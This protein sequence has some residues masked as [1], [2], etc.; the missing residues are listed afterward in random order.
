MMTLEHD[1]LIGRWESRNGAHVA[2]LWKMHGSGYYYT[3]NG[4][5][6]YFGNDI[7]EAQAIAMMEERCQPGMGYFQP[8]ANKTAMRRV[9]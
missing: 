6:G 7:N 3:G 9:K 1:T 2:E 4:C 8:D 5:S